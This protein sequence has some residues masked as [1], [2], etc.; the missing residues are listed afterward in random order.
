MGMAWKVQKLKDGAWVDVVDRTGAGREYEDPAIANDWI[1]GMQFLDAGTYRAVELGTAPA[2]RT[3]REVLLEILQQTAMC[4]AELHQ[5][6]QR[7]HRADPTSPLLS[8]QG[9]RTLR[10]RMLRRGLIRP[11]KE[12][13]TMPSGFTATVW[14][15]TGGDHGHA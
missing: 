8:P 3:P 14:E 9:V 12:R 15:M 11:A 1:T 13:K 6:L 10:L 4:D 7:R 2:Q 5:E